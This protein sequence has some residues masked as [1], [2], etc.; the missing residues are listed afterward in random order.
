MTEI[1]RKKDI[2][3]K[4]GGMQ[5]KTELLL[6]EFAELNLI[7]EQEKKDIHSFLVNRADGTYEFL[8]KHMTEAMEIKV[9]TNE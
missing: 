6:R 5:L 1:K 9:G 8:R 2:I 7:S 4:L 3:E